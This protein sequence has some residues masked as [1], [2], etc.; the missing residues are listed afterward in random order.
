MRGKHGDLTPLS[1][2]G[3]IGEERLGDFLQLRRTPKIS[4][5]S[6]YLQMIL[7]EEELLE[8]GNYGKW[9]VYY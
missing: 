4:L 8:K 3:R 2:I 1:M 9:D 7:R 6:P 5:C